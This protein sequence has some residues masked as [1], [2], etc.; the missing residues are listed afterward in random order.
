MIVMALATYGLSILI[1]GQPA[2]TFL[3]SGSY[4]SSKQKKHKYFNN[5][6][7]KTADM[8]ISVLKNQ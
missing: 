1:S 8:L 5:I 4:D 3:D 2:L 7:K 6:D